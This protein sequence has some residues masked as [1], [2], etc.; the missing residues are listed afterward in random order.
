M[1]HDWLTRPPTGT[2]CNPQ[3]IDTTT[4]TVWSSIRI[5]AFLIEAAIWCTRSLPTI[6]HQPS[7]FSIDL[8]FIP[9]HGLL[10]NSMQ[11]PFCSVQ[12]VCNLWNNILTWYWDIEGHV[13]GKGKDCNAMQRPS[14]LM[15][16]IPGN[17]TYPLAGWWFISYGSFPR[18]TCCSSKIKQSEEVCWRLW[19]LVYSEH[20]SALASLGEL[21]I[22]TVLTTLR[23]G[24]CE[25]EQQW[26]SRI[27]QYTYV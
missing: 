16:M 26:F 3:W 19:Y 11:Y 8:R 25:P 1:I 17:Y 9:K 13:C 27:L 2:K 21:S 4:T 5:V 12:I 7:T 6:N 18:P 20:S 14:I 22:G 15:S 23:E 24:K 10:W